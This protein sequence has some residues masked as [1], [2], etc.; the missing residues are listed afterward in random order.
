MAISYSD[1]SINRYERFAWIPILIAFL[2]AIGTGGKHLSNPVPLPSATGPLVLSFG[3]AIAGFTITYSP[4]SSDF[5]C[6][7][8]K[9]GPRLVDAIDVT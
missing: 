1:N 5:T 7:L 9:D 4:L 6:Y 8:R 3:A 2:V